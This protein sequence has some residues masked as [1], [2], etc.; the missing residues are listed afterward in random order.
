MAAPIVPQPE[1]RRHGDGF[2]GHHLP[3]KTRRALLRFAVA[4]ALVIVAL[5]VTTASAA[6]P[7]TWRIVALGDSIPY[8]G[9]YCGGCTPFP[10]LLGSALA[11]ASGHPVTVTNLGFPGLQTVE[12]VTSVRWDRDVRAAIAAADIVTI[13]TGHNDT[14]WNSRHDKCDGGRAWFGVYA[15]ADWGS[16]RGACLAQ[17]SAS[18]GNRLR[19]ILSMVRDLRG[20]KPTLVELTTDWNQ[21]IGKPGITASAR[22]ASKA[23]LDQFASVTCAAARAWSARCGDVYHAFNGPSGTAS[24]GSLLAK[25]HDHASQAGHRAIATKLAAFVFAPLTR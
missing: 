15:N 25:D 13:T 3:V 22:S 18:L 21:V 23:V 24:A 7:R 6:T 11:R 14:P 1:R 12:L 5:G 16:Y 17:A 4:I 10:T 19:S 2:P 9:V 8:G 20:G